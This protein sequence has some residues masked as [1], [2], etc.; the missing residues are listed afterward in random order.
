M[1][2]RWGMGGRGP[3]SPE[4]DVEISK[5]VGRRRWAVADVIEDGGGVGCA[6]DVDEGCGVQEP[7]VEEVGGLPAGL[8]GV[9]AEG[10]D[11]GGGAGV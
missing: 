8:E 9:G 7:R 2:A 10:E 6:E 3:G 5:I 4:D 11:G 1:L